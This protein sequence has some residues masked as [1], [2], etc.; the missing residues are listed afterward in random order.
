ME[1]E[2][3]D[4]LLVDDNPADA[5]LIKEMLVDA[6]GSFSVRCAGRLDE[7][8]EAVAS[9]RFGIILLDLMLPD[10][11]GFDT[12]SAMH[13]MAGAM[14]IVVLTGLSDENLAAR[15]V[16][17]G[18]QDYL[19]KGQVDTPMLVRAMRFAIERKRQTSA[20][21]GGRPREKER[22]R[23]K[24]I[25]SGPA[26]R[27][28]ED[29]VH[30]VAKTSNTSV[31]IKGE[32]GTGKGVVASAIHSVSSRANEPFI[33][34]NCGAIPDTLLETEMFGYEKGAFTDA[35]TAKKGLFELAEGGTVFLDEIGDMDMKLQPKLLQFLESR[36]FRKVGGTRDI[37]VNL[38]VIAATNKDLESMVREK[39]FR[40]DLFYRLKV[41][42]ITLPPLRDRK[43]DIISL[44]EHF[45]VMYS[46][47][48]GAVKKLSPEC[49]DILLSYAWPGNIR[50][51]KNVIE[52]ATI[53]AGGDEIKKE[54]LPGELLS[55]S[56]SRKAEAPFASSL[57][58]EEVEKAH[59]L[60][61]LKSVGNNKTAASNILGISRLT[62]RKKLTDYGL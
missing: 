62:L 13:G 53:V 2:A 19:V 36:A 50:E 48:G 29:L 6:E 45:I 60:H 40:E 55:V 21:Q 15:A 51:L 8:L 16:R 1:G 34:I 39:R 47:A 4:I 27:E 58:L 38:R 42:V 17:A 37:R 23:L 54:D 10:S 57:S 5:R 24:M 59:I 33:E 41:M 12:F 26:F 35:K 32:T 31:L 3:L 56:A 20:R 30:T 9:S 25:G 44:A 11:R 49:R 22:G 52:H 28:I 14:P 61:V 46:E 7:A 18:A 43:E